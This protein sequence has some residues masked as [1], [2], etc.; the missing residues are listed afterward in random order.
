MSI[1]YINRRQVQGSRHKYQEMFGRVCDLQLQRQFSSDCEL[2]IMFCIDAS[3][4]RQCVAN[5]IPYIL[6]ATDSDGMKWKKCMEFEKEVVLNAAAVLTNTQEILDFFHEEYGLEG[7]HTVH[8]RPLKKDLDFTPLEKLKG[9]NIVYSG[10]I[11]LKDNPYD[12]RNYTEIFGL[13]RDAGWTVHIYPAWGNTNGLDEYERL[14]CVLHHPV[15]QGSLYRELSQYQAGFQGYG[16]GKLQKYVEIARPNKLWEYLGAGIPT[17]GYNTGA[18]GEIYNGK[19]G[20]V[21]ATPS[22]IKKITPKVLKMKIDEEMRMEQTMDKELYVFYELL[23]EAAKNIEKKLAAYVKPM[24][25]PIRL[26]KDVNYNGHI[27]MKDEMINRELA[28]GMRSL[29]LLDDVRIA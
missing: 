5:S 7:G 25:Y 9:K 22:D 20:L 26:G 3:I 24:R 1:E 14:G 8:L 21:A 12:Y 23:D 2:A 16:F 18:G 29:G 19:W 27:Y 4:Y 6:V 13:L 15:K 17:L 28:I 10:G 11:V